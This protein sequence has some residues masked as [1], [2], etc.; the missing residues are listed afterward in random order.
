MSAVCIVRQVALPIGLITALILSAPAASAGMITYTDYT[1]DLSGM[2][3]GHVPPVLEVQAKGHGTTEWGAVSWTGTDDL[4]SGD[5]K[6]AG[7]N[8]RSINELLAEG[9]TQDLFGIVLN[10]NE[11]VGRDVTVQ[12]F[13]LDIYAPTGGAPI[14]SVPL[15]GG[16]LTLPQA[17][18][19]QGG[20][21][22][23]F[24]VQLTDEEW[25]TYFA[26]APANRIGMSIPSDQPI[27]NVSG[28]G[29]SFTVAAIPEPAAVA[30]LAAGSVIV[31]SSRPRRTC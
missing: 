1:V 3:F 22:H 30:I 18:P 28:G 26:G 7:S 16:P 20:A 4:L 14:F 19:G 11:N 25:K 13:S 9:L 24:L 8:T 17:E 15:V 12:A 27:Q 31:V 5:A 29:E 10:I 21:G 6:S 2:G 23:L